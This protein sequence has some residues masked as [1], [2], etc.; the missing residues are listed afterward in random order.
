MLRE[1]T[2]HAMMG[3]SK[4][5]LKNFIITIFVLLLAMCLSLA[6]ELKSSNRERRE[7]GEHHREEIARLNEDCR[8][9]NELKNNEIKTIL[10]ETVTNQVKI[11]A[12]L[13][14]WKQLY[15]RNKR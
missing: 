14:K 11:Q 12:E 3:I 2:W 6:L 5:F 1:A 13:D 4:M 7:E 10:I 15:Q 9:L 8:K